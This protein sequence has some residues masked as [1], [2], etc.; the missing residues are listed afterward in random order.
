[1][2]TTQKGKTDVVGTPLNA[3][4]L[5]LA[6]L[7]EIE[8]NNVKLRQGQTRKVTTIS[9]TEIERSQPIEKYIS[10]PLQRASKAQIAILKDANLT[11]HDKLEDFTEKDFKDIRR[12][13]D[14][15]P[16]SK[17]IN[18]AQAYLKTKFLKQSVDIVTSDGL[19][20]FIGYVKG[21]TDHYESQKIYRQWLKSVIEEN[22]FSWA[23]RA[24]LAKP[25]DQIVDEKITKLIDFIKEKPQSVIVFVNSQQTA[26]VLA[27][28]LV[29]NGIKVRSV[30]AK[31]KSSQKSIEDWEDFKARTYQVFIS[32]S[33]KDSNTGAIEC[34]ILMYN[35]SKKAIR[36]TAKILKAKNSNVN[37]VSILATKG[38]EEEQSAKSA[39]YIIRNSLRPKRKS[40]KDSRQKNFKFS[41]I[42]RGA[43]QTNSNQ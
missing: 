29:A 41:G 6:F 36:S 17:R 26:D 42:L 24:A 5:E 1:M 8:Q 20:A 22:N 32:T 7:K 4:P 35:P 33:V 38:T 30:E 14:S 11:A 10:T 2:S 18:L 37:E 16:L 28:K 21:T 40:T 34:S 15:F 13:L 23:W 9:I 12:A 19:E 39:E 43:S 3:P 25:K 31:M 27:K